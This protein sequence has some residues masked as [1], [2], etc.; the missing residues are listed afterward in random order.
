MKAK[1]LLVVAAAVALFAG[2]YF[3]FGGGGGSGSGSFSGEKALAHA[4]SVIA[5]GE[6]T[7]GSEGIR[8]AQAYIESALADAG[9]TTV[10]QEFEADTPRG[11][12]PF[13]NIR[14]RLAREGGAIDWADGGGLT[15]IGSHYDTK[16][17]DSFTF[18]GAN[19]G[20]SSTGALIEL[21]R[22]LAAAPE[23]ARQ[24]ELIFFDGEECIGENY[25]A[26]DGLYGSREYAKLWR[27]A[28]PAKKPVRGLVLDMIGDPQLNVNP[29]QDSPRPLLL[30]LYAAANDLG[31]R[32]VFG[33]NQTDILDDHVP[34]NQAGIPTLDI[35]DL[36][37]PHWHQEG[38]TADKLSASS[39]EIVGRVT[40]RLL[41][42]L[43]I[44][45]K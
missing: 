12:L 18:V 3:V 25:T 16:F 6:R 29:P 33:L 39:L 17:F 1:P 5:F 20:G 30:A 40:V 19:D 42:R 8:K 28:P 27:G 44:D 36:D 38:D 10:R 45:G 21:A 14:A 24:I 2:L 37:Y 4:S 31:H 35:I 34:L 26:T 13:V 43:I 22:V 23:L 15:L 41:E 7:P 9:W 11:K 32:K